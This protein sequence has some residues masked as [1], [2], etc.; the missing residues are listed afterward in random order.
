MLQGMLQLLAQHCDLSLSRMGSGKC[1]IKGYKVDRVKLLENFI[2][3]REDPENVR[4]MGLWEKFPVPFLY[5]ASGVEPE[6]GISLVVVLA[7]G[8][9]E[10][11]VEKKTIV[12][13]SEPYTKVFTMGMWVR[14]D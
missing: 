10:S 4:Y 6:G 14:D 11:E 9:N 2:P 12:E 7:E 13:F 3:T 5:L 1:Y 8:Y